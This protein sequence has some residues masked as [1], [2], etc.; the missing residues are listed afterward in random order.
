MQTIIK[1]RGIKKS[2]VLMLSILILLTAFLPTT[3]FANSYLWRGGTVIQYE[4]TSAP[5]STAGDNK[6]TVVAVG[7][8]ELGNPGNITV[9]LQKYVLSGYVT[10]K[11]MTVPT[12]GSSNP[13]LRDYPV[14]TNTNYRLVYSCGGSYGKDIADISM[15]VSIW[16]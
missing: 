4:T 16:S 3:A 13:I 11:T 6:L 5:F 1:K 12:D 15:G 8:V 10:V 9:K 2:L 7:T 14:D